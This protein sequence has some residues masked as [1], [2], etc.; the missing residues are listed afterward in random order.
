MVLELYAMDWTPFFQFGLFLL[1]YKSFKFM[2]LNVS[3][4]NEKIWFL[5]WPHRI[6]TIV[7]LRHGD[8]VSWLVTCPYQSFSRE[9][10]SKKSLIFHNRFNKIMK[11]EFNSF[12]FLWFWETSSKFVGYPELKVYVEKIKGANENSTSE[13]F[14]VFTLIERLAFLCQS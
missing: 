4:F 10:M 6:L 13:R 11:L 5:N 9:L 3:K 14:W 1:C 2:T 12:F 8:L 7:I